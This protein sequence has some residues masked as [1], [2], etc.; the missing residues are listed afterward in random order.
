MRKYG[1]IG[2]TFNP[3]HL[4]HL[5]IAYEAKE[6][7]QLDKVIFMPAGN[8]PHK[9][10]KDIVDASDRFNMVK[11]AIKSYDGFE[12]SDYEIKK[13]GLS[14]TYK[15]LEDLKSSDIDIFFI[16]GADSLMNI[17]KWK[18]PDR[19]LAN[20][21]FVVFNRGDIERDILEAQ[22][23]KIEDRYSATVILLDVA[24]IDISS[25]MIRNRIKEGKRVDF[26]LP[27]DVLEYINL[28]SLYEGE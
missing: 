9:I 13:D 11:Q 23:K 17:E 18:R 2:G 20:C 4:A 21:N 27:K 3:I 26:F 16:S 19:I 5:Y 1:I 15:T 8:P 14:Y 25:S 6:Q 12:I 7:L 10:N 22:K 24:D 28:N